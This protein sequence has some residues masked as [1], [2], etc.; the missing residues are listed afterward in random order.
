MTHLSINQK[1]ELIDI[2]NTFL[3]DS[4]ILKMKEIPMHRG[5][6]CY[7]HSF[8][9]AKLS[10]KRALKRKGYNLKALLI[11]SILHDYYLYDWR[12]EKECKKRHGRKHPYIAVENAKRDFKISEEIENIMRS[13]MWP[14][15][16]KDFPK[17]KEA[18]MLNYIDDV[19]ATREFLTSKNYKKKRE[20]KYLKYISNLFDE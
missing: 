9:V 17:S 15:T 14:L 12:K 7:I 13:H 18:K 16:I 8:K 2:Y 11:A 4:H 6:N 3:N 19:V 5:S 10:I 1:Q 20:E